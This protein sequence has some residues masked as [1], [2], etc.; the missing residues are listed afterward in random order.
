MLLKPDI[1]I[2]IT[3]LEFEF[4]SKKI[5]VRYRWIA[6][7]RTASLSSIQYWPCCNS[8]ANNRWVAG[9]VAFSSDY[10]TG[11]LR[12]LI[13]HHLLRLATLNKAGR[14]LPFGFPSTRLILII[15]WTWLGDKPKY[16]SARDIALLD[17]AH[18]LNPMRNRQ[19][20]CLIVSWVCL[21]QTRKFDSN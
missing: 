6:N 4:P 3:K 10:L 14:L 8:R 7:P 15:P 2:Q 12:L 17:S 19:L 1:H 11:S 5:V 20:S 9:V 16:L 13:Q 18:F 21:R